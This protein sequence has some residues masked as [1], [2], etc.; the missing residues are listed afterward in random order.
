MWEYHMPPSWPHSLGFFP[1]TSHEVSPHILVHITYGPTTTPCSPHPSH[2]PHHFFTLTPSIPPF[3][4]FSP[5]HLMHHLGVLRFVVEMPFLHDTMVELVVRI[6]FYTIFV[7]KN[8]MLDGW[9]KV[10]RTRH[11]S[12]PHH[13]LFTSTLSTI[14]NSTM[15][16]HNM[17]SPKTVKPLCHMSHVL[18]PT[19]RWCQL[20]A[21]I[22]T[23]QRHPHIP[24]RMVNLGKSGR[25]CV[26]CRWLIL[27]WNGTL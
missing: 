27:Y 23:L 4:V 14:K 8:F 17:C 1:L 18:H 3:H 16:V 7:P 22:T 12:N 15:W 21:T 9:A 25:K 20:D 2:T 6:M 13:L 11:M 26:T 24:N 5:H 19:F 10:C